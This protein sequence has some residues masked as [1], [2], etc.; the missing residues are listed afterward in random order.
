MC[1]LTQPLTAH[2]GAARPGGSPVNRALL[3]VFF[4]TD[5]NKKQSGRFGKSNDLHAVG[6]IGAG[7]MGSGIA[8]TIA[9]GGFETLCFDTSSE[10]LKKAQE[11]VRIGRYGFERAVSRG[12]IAQEDAD[13]ALDRLTFIGDLEAT[14]QTDLVIECVPENLA[15]KIKVFR[16]LDGMAPTDTVLASNTSGF[17]IAAIA[18]GSKARSRAAR[19]Q[20][21]SIPGR[22]CQWPGSSGRR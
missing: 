7:V 22:R 9:S 10:A 15:L 14:A 17:S 5:R 19:A 4:L 11:L 18:A 12:K 21:R 16:E 1:G 2:R 3:N 6:V 13:A 8:Q 20:R